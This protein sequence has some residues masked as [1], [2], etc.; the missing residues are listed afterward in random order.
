LSIF[1]SFFIVSAGIH[2]ATSKTAEY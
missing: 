2:G 1:R